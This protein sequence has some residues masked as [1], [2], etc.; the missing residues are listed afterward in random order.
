MYMDFY[1]LP[2]LLSGKELSLPM[3]EM[4]VQSLGWEDP[5][6][7][8]MA[9]YSSIFA[10]EIPWTVESDGPQSMWSLNKHN[11]ATEQ[12]QWISMC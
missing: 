1:G 6:G 10:Q 3:Q 2:W 12:Q 8:E 5:V 11:L 7:K 4:W 9:T